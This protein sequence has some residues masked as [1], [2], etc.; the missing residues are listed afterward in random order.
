MN[1]KR[2]PLERVRHNNIIQEGGVAFP[3]LVLLAN[4]LLEIVSRKR[5]SSLHRCSARSGDPCS[6][7]RRASVTSSVRSSVAVIQIHVMLRGGK[8]SQQGP[9]AVPVTSNLPAYYATSRTWLP[10]LRSAG[11]QEDTQGRPVGRCFGASTWMIKS[12]KPTICIFLPY[13]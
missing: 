7:Q 2:W 11:K 5:F 9:H 13:Y 4:D 12:A 10:E 8:V 1:G 6:N 3:N